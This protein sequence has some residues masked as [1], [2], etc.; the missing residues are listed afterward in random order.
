M[1]KRLI[2]LTEE[3]LLFIGRLAATPVVA[4]LST[5]YKGCRPLIKS[6]FYPRINYLKKHK[7]IQQSGHAFKLTPKGQEKVKYIKWK[8]KKVDFKKWDKK[9]RIFSFDIPEKKRQLRENL[10]KK[11]RLLNFV[12]L[13]DSLWITP[14]AIENDIR[15]LLELLEIK[16]FVRYMIVEKIN[17]DRDLRKK[18]FR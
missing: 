13:H 9:W 6:Q 12:H 10:R 16:Y 11:L 3:I 7:Y 2:N 5:P 1:K 15:E 18:F 8:L 4:F 14:L 17:F